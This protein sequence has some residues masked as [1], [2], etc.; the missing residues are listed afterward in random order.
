MEVSQYVLIY[1][2][3]GITVQWDGHNGVYVRMAGEFRNN[4]C[5]LCG[6]F[7]G[8]P[9]DD[10]TTLGGSLVSSPS[11]FGNSYK[12]TRLTEVCSDVTEQ[13]EV[14]PCNRLTAQDKISVGELCNVIYAP[15]FSPCHAVVS[16]DLFVRMCEEDVCSCNFTSDP[17]CP[18]DAL[19]Q[20][21][22]ACARNGITLNWRKPQFCSKF[23]NETFRKRIVL[24]FIVQ[25]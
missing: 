23:K 7:N 18:C 4:T 6:N 20:Y 13:Q 25:L 14:F 3:S 11:A 5:G 8:N 15:D 12:M 16:P 21:S 1:G 2:F 17:S 10:F 9:D 24:D 22:R 19:T